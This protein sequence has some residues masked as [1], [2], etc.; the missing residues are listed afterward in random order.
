MFKKSSF[1]RLL[2]LVSSL[3]ICL[4]IHNPFEP[5]TSRAHVLLPRRRGAGIY[6][7]SCQE[8][9]G[10]GYAECYGTCYNAGAGETCCEGNCTYIYYCFVSS[11]IDARPDK[12]PNGQYCGYGPYS[13]C[14]FDVRPSPPSHLDQVKRTE[15]DSIYPAVP[16]PHR[17]R[18]TLCHR[19]TPTQLATRRW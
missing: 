19:R 2:S 8:T 1:I 7:E 3:P 18:R 4:A 5:G 9:Y 15:A 14:C 16:N 12:C 11:R 10:S 13:Y 6:Q 17:M